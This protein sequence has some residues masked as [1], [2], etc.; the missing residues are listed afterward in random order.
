LNNTETDTAH[1]LE[2]PN[3]ASPCLL[4]NL[5]RAWHEVIPNDWDAECKMKNRWVLYND[6]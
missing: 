5:K 3:C 1:R 4:E 2:I 6:L